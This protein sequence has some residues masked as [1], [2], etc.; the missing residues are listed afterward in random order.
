MSEKAEDNKLGL[1]KSEWD[2]LASSLAR[3]RVELDKTAREAEAIKHYQNTLRQE[4]Y[5]EQLRVMGRAVINKC[6]YR[7]W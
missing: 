5:K 7:V 2:K 4:S 1:D 3:A 6:L